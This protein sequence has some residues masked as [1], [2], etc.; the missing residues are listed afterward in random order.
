M[1]RRYLD[2]I[3]VDPD[4]ADGLAKGDRD[5]SEEDLGML[6]RA[7]L[8]SVPFENLSQHVHPASSDGAFPAV[9]VSD[10]PTLDVDRTLRKIVDDRR[11]G[12]CWEI[13]VAF[14]WLLTNLGYAVRFGNCNVATPDGPVP[15]HLCLFV[16]GLREDERA[17]HVDPGFGDAPRTPIPAMLLGVD[18]AAVAVAVTKDPMIGDEYAFAAND[19]SRASEL[20]QSPAQSERFD[21]VLLRRRNKGGIRSSPVVDY[22]GAP[23]DEGE[24]EATTPPDDGFEPVYLLNLGDDLAGD[25]DE[26]REGLARVLVDDPEANIFARKRLCIL[27]RENGFDFV[28]SAYRKEVRDGTEVSRRPLETE[29]E[30][31]EA[32]AEIAGIR[33]GW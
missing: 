33:L 19:A 2:R 22:R 21:A 13:N 20:R 7:H 4:L 29:A 18:G 8:T 25:C 6:L 31:R 10:L 1:L 12:F 32:L 11:G 17:L 14:R 15:G 9:P 27:L 23:P 5:P 28:G 26:F 24:A 16:D 3:G 30:Y